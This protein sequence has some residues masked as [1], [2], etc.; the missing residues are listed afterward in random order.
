[1]KSITLLIAVMAIFSYQVQGQQSNELLSKKGYK[2]LPEAG[3]LS[4]GFDAVPLVN[5][6]LNAINIMENTGQTAQNPGFMSGY[7]QIIVGKYFVSSNTAYRAKFGIGIDAD[8]SITY[9]D[10]PLADPADEDPNQLQNISK[11]R[12]T[13][14]FL[15]GGI[16]QRHGASRVQG[17]YGAE[18]LLTLASSKTA[19][20]YGVKWNEE[21]EDAGLV[22]DGDERLLSDRAGTLFGLGG[23]GFIGVEYFFAPKMAI[24][25][26][27]GIGFIFSNSGK[28][29]LVNEVYNS[30]EGSSSTVE[31]FGTTSGRSFEMSVD[32]SNASLNLLIY[33]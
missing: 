1:M 22:N 12:S 6:A 7:D 10:D 9:F 23:R 21:T 33:F 25:A 26:E 13:N 16:E 15:S 28:S 8:N 3:N 27:Y 20:E 19:Q 4:V 5:F 32:N 17:Y 31:E 29:K 30:D 24:S 2:I 11:Q 14:I 18:G